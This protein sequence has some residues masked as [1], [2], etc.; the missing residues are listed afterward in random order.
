[1]PVSKKTR[2]KEPRRGPGIYLTAETLTGLQLL[3]HVSLTAM[4]EGTACEADLHNVIARVNLGYVMLTQW[5]ESDGALEALLDALDA[6]R[7][8]RPEM[9]A[10]PLG[11][12]QVEALGYAL[13][14]SDLILQESSKREITKALTK[15][16]E[17]AATDTRI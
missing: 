10:Y 2:R 9:L 14:L 4:A 15:V 7:E 5:W 11:Q 17:L 3:P 16:I 13:L 1:M 12:P 8:M 6:L